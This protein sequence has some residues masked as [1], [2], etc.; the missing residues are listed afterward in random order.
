MA[1]LTASCKAR[2]TAR[3]C[4]PFPYGSA[5]LNMTTMTTSNQAGQH[6]VLDPSLLGRP[7]HMLHVF[8]AQLRED[9]AQAMRL[10]MSRRYWGGFQVDAVQ[11]ARSDGALDPGRWVSF[12]AAPSQIGFALERKVLL[13]VLN[14]RYSRSDAK[15][16][17]MPDPATVRVTATEERLAVVLGQHLTATLL[18]RIAVNLDN[19][20]VPER[21]SGPAGDLPV[22]PGTK[23]AKGG[24]LIAVTVSD[25]NAG[26]SGQFWFSL[27]KQTITDILQGLLPARAQTKKSLQGERALATR[28]QLKLD[29]RLV[30]KEMPLGSLFD[31]RVGDVIPVSLSRTAV[32]LEDSLLFTAE[33]SEHKGKLCLTSFEDAE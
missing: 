6:Q 15:A 12:T 30:T 28:L 18:N 10:P 8:A 2:H 33:V 22:Q 9:L 5:C 31:L 32:L 20:P 11:V 14:Y 17:A 7:V 23:P 4:R 3:Q 21:R 13:S 27:D 25:V 16:A 26:H 29:G 1:R 19:A 24:W